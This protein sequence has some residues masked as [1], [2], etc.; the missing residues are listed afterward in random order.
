MI[1]Q[2]TRSKDRT[3][4]IYNSDFRQKSSSAWFEVVPIAGC[5]GLN[6]NGPHRLIRRALLEM[7]RTCDLT[8][9]TGSLGWAWVS[10]AQTRSSLDVELSVSSPAHL[11]ACSRAS[12]HSDSKLNCKPAPIKCFLSCCGHGVSSQQQ[13]PELRY[14][15]KLRNRV[16]PLPRIGWSRAQARVLY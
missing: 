2:A 14:A 10:E 16:T 7:I 15:V 3:V 6:E 4:F 8:G 5:G 13:K 12:S 1:P 9:G 11:P